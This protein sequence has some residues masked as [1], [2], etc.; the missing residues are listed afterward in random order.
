MDN[1]PKYPIYVPSKGRADV[2][3]TAQFF[4][5]D[6]VDFKI[7]V[8][9][10][11]EAD[12]LKFFDKKYLL[13]LPK[14]NQGLIYSRLWIRQHSAKNGFQRH[15]QFDDNIR[16][17][18]RL[19]KGKRIRCNARIAIKAIEDFTDRYENIGISGFNYT[20]FVMNDTKKPFMTN[21]HV[22]SAFLL[23]NSIPYKW[24]LEW[25]DDVD[26]CLQV[27]S[28]GLCTVSFNSFMVDKIATMK[29]KGGCTTDYLDKAKDTRLKGAQLLQA[30][31]PE[32]V[33]VK[34]K[35]GR[36]HFSIKNAWRDF[37]TPLVRRKDID[38]EALKKPNNYGMKLTEI[39]KVKSKSL[40]KML[41]ED[42][43]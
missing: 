8:E 9:P 23:N 21:V 15:W 22:Y 19:Q 28:G 29:V 14:N 25:N 32:M 37:T 20:M 5:E 31:W 13:I 35:Y 38:W 30:N 11:Q 18:R 27:L 42:R 6:G 33:K 34:W 24:R 4:I 10:S 39:K 43:K 1:T 16:L 2:C 40:K 12:Y 41:K 36:W 3:F 17:I 26:M 7:V